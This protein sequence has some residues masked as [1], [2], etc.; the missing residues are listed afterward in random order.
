MGVS[1]EQR[2]DSLYA[3][4]LDQATATLAYVGEA[5]PSASSAAAIWRIKRLDTTAGLVIQW[6]DGNSHF[7][8][9]WDDRATLSYS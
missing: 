1:S 6:A 2:S 9:V 3:L 4:R 8:N 7:D 5:S